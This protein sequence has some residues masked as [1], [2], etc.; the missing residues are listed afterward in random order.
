MKISKSDDGS[1]EI[2]P[3]STLFVEVLNRFPRKP[4]K[5]ILRSVCQQSLH[6]FLISPLPSKTPWDFHQLLG[7]NLSYTEQVHFVRIPV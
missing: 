1:I 4:S 5:C 3:L 6:S 2:T 7:D